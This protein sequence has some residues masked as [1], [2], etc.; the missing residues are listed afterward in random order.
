[1]QELVHELPA[2][3]RANETGHRMHMNCNSMLHLGLSRTDPNERKLGL[4][5]MTLT[6]VP[7]YT[8]NCMVQWKVQVVDYSPWVSHQAGHAI[9]VQPRL[10]AET[11]SFTNNSAVPRSS[12]EALGNCNLFPAQ[13][14]GEH[15][16][17]RH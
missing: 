16:V 15:D 2:P 6:P 17:H 1:V 13:S 4:V 9:A 12:A 8:V 11:S 10:V 7:T 14:A 5:I 3:A